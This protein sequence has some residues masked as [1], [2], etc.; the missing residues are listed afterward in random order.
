[1]AQRLARWAETPSEPASQPSAMDIVR[2]PHLSVDGKRFLLMNRAYDEHLLDQRA[3][4]AIGTRW[5]RLQEID[6]VLL[7]LESVG[8]SASESSIAA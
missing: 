3:G 5:S 4:D 1:M 2:D 6:Q 7:A 8:V